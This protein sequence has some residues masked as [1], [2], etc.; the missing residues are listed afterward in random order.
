MSAEDVEAL[1]GV[2]LVFAG[3]LACVVFGIR[4]AKKKNRSPHWMWFGLHPLGALIVLLVMK[5]VKPLKVCPKCFQK[6]T[7]LA[8][9]CPYCRH[10]FVPDSALEAQGSQPPVAEAERQFAVEPPKPYSVGGLI[11]AWVTTGFCVV[12]LIAKASQQRFELQMFAAYLFANVALFWR[13]YCPPMRWWQ[14]ILVWVGGLVAGASF[15]VFMGP[16]TFQEQ[17]ADPRTVSLAHLGAFIVVLGLGA[18]L[19]WLGFWR[20]LGPKQKSM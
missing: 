3:W 13:A 15:S 6:M 9:V 17:I 12:T 4:L 14:G 11:A 10:A 18:V 8:Q 2:L 20:R 5:F 16:P 1:F 19:I 7:A